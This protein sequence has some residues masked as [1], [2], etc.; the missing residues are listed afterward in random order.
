MRDLQCEFC[1]KFPTMKYVKNSYV[2]YCCDDHK[3][4]LHKLLH[5]DL[6]IDTYS[7]QKIKQS[8]EYI[9]EEDNKSP[10]LSLLSEIEQ[11]VFK[12]LKYLR[13][14]FDESLTRLTAE[15]V[16]FLAYVSF[17]H[18]TMKMGQIIANEQG[19]LPFL[20]TK[21]QVFVE[22]IQNHLTVDDFVCCKICDQTIDEIYNKYLEV[23]NGEK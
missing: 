21:D 15:K 6:G 5:L 1:T 22:H 3:E 8:Q 23:F 4:K 19:D 17:N 16:L 2:R 13:G 12:G 20:K 18:A 11:S 9:N 10:P 7:F 14:D